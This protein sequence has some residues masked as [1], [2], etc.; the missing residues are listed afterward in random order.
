MTSSRM[1]RAAHASHPDWKEAAAQVVAGL[2]NLD[3]AYHLGFLYV[4][5]AFAPSLDEIA[6]FLRQT[7]GVGHWVGTV[8]L[9]VCGTAREYFDAPAMSV[10]V[11]PFAESAFRIFGDARSETLQSIDQ[12]GEWLNEGT[13]PLAVVHGDPTNQELPLLIEALSDAT[14]GFLV[15]GLSASRGSH[16]QFADEIVDSGLSGV[17]ISP[18]AVPLVTGLTQGCSPI[19]PAHEITEAEQ[20]VL[21]TLDS[22]PALD[23]F[24]EDIGEELAQDLQRCAGLIFVALP[25]EG[26]DTGDYLVRNLIGIDP[27]SGAVAIGERVETG[28]SVMFCRRDQDSAEKDLRRMARKLKQR[29]DGDVKG[30]L[31]FSCVARGPNQFGP[32]SRELGI[33]AEELGAFPLAGLFANGEISHNRLY[34]YTG[35]LTLFL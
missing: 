26:S 20:N 2:E 12:E 6:K 33:I 27:Q 30:G 32:D 34:G 3:G 8:G 21:L 24:R 22:R 25:V 17:M 11:A 29:A 5:D 19:G 35:V 28:Q 10:L 31:Y 18:A 13:P 15:G 7:T 9:G 14:G 1:F 23:V 4:S 16:T